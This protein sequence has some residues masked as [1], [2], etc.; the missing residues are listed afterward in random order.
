MEELEKTLAFEEPDK[1]SLMYKLKE[2][3][4]LYVIDQV[5]PSTQSRKEISPTRYDFNANDF[6]H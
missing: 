5:L 1:D 3:A 2:C 4:K 6:T